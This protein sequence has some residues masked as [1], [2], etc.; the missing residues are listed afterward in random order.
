M[1]KLYR[2]IDTSTDTIVAESIG[3]HTVARELLEFWRRDYPQN[4]FEIEP[5]H[6]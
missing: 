5:Y 3:S 6:K 1:Q 4:R 2:I